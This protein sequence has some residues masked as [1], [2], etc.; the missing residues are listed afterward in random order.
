MREPDLE[1]TPRRPE[2]PGAAHEPLV[3]GLVNNMPDGALQATER[4]FRSLLNGAAGASYDV[5][6]RVFS[7]PELTRSDEG[8]AYVS[9]HY[10]PIALL[11]NGVLDGLIVTGTEPRTTIIP[12]EA[13]WPSL[14][15]LVDWAVDSS[16]PTVWSCLAAHAAVLYL[17]GV[18]RRRLDRKLSGVF[19][20]TKRGADP[21]LAG[22]PA[23][24]RVPHSRLNTLDPEPLISAGYDVVSCSEEAG[25]DT[26]VLR[27]HAPFLFFQGHPEYD[28]D[29]LFREYRRDVGRFLAGTTSKYPDMPHGYFD[30]TTVAALVAFRA[31]VERDRSE[32]R[33]TEFP[34][35]ELREQS[36]P[37][38]RDVALR[39]YE[40]W[41]SAIA[42]RRSR[43]AVAVG[44]GAFAAPGA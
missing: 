6:L 4:Q 8:R 31:R 33:L 14:T 2:R 24:W 10:E 1:P 17:D 3:I 26:F 43:E 39:L 19:G 9:E 7:F 16:T 42:T 21:L 28:G 40:N 36:L 5:E 12:D 35:V 13:Y 30:E 25:V 27:R 11:W 18:V 29:T 34:L 32:V 20:C 41:L 15:R 44:C 38:W 22:L 23:S 37:P